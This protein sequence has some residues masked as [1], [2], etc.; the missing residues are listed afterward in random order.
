MPPINH[1]LVDMDGVLCDF[2]GAA[3]DLHRRGDALI[4]WPLGEYDIAAVLGMTEN[5]FWLPIDLSMA[6]WSTIPAC[7]W[8][9]DLVALLDDTGIPWTVATSPSFC[10]Q[11]AAGKLQWLQRHFCRDFR[12]YMMG[13]HKPLLAL[14]DTVLIDDCDRNVD[15]FREA[16][17]RAILFPQPWNKLHFLAE[18]IDNLDHVS[19]MLTELARCP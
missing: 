13:P 5:Q 7:P 17:G 19:E 16:G 18:P 6:F 14:P 8:F 12:A 9:A 2:V 1:I 4:T 10:P 11:S 15:A 3:L